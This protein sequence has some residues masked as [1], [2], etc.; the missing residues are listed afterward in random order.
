MVGEEIGMAGFSVYINNENIILAS[1]QCPRKRSGYEGDVLIDSVEC[2]TERVSC[3]SFD[4]AKTIVNIYFSA[5][6][7]CMYVRYCVSN[8]YEAKIFESNIFVED[9]CRRGF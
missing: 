8:H 9:A 6:Y 3:V 2:V 7:V 5:K 1:D 4:D